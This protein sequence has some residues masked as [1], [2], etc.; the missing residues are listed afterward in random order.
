[1]EHKKVKTFIMRSFFPFPYIKVSS[2]SLVQVCSNAVFLI[3]RANNFIRSF[4][5]CVVHFGLSQGLTSYRDSLKN[6][7]VLSEDKWKSVLAKF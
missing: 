1:M 6:S 3:L 5:C 7:W 4:G 2:E